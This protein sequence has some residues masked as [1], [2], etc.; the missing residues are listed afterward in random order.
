MS[1]DYAWDIYEV[2]KEQIEDQLPEVEPYILALN[3]PDDVSENIN[4]LFRLFHNY[5][6][7]ADYLSLKPLK[8][9]S[10]K[11]ETVLGC[12][13]DENKIVE[14]SIIEWLLQI[15]DQLDR[16]LE[17]MNNYELELQ[18]APSLLKIKFKISKS[19][20]SVA[21]TLKALSIL[22]IDND[23]KRADKI[24]AY[25][26]QIAKNAKSSSSK[27]CSE[28]IKDYGIIII[29]LDKFNYPIIEFILKN[30][31]D[32]PI[33]S[34][35]NTINLSSRKKLLKLGAN[36]TILN[37]LNSK[38]IQRE[39]SLITKTYYSSRKILIDN[40]KIGEFIQTL[41]PLPNTI[42]K[43]VNVCDDENSAIIDLIKIVKTDPIITANI[44]KSANSPLYGSTRLTTIDQAITRLGK[45]AIKALAMCGMFKNLNPL[46]LSAYEIDEDTFSKVSMSRLS[47]ILK[48]YSKVSIA[49]LSILTSTA[50]LGNIGQL[51]ISKE[52]INIQQD[53]N[54]QKLYTEFD[55]RYAEE[56]IMHITTTMLSAQILN[57]WKLSNDIVDIISFSD[58]PLEAPD[59]FK[60]LAV[61]NHIVY[62]LIDIVGNVSDHIPKDV[63]VLMKK[64]DLDPLPLK[65]ALDFILENN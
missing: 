23:T 35:F 31:P 34:V 46:N 30:Y 56:S 36:N 45:R 32:L 25:L 43:I 28:K 58:N 26:K 63:L 10:H 40:K 14:N 60:K 50:L 3:R 22:Y 13:R 54:F 62:S 27:D 1:L 55:I 33:I 39:L 64:F 37:P 15:K 2:F 9:L 24:V 52:L 11:A 19:H 12:L 18:E 8:S 44:L 38:K 29:N 4:N 61:A 17:Q 51:L 53:D 6:A 42:F 59:E 7:T 65:K 48:W 47:L 57:H 21:D 49:D 16:W 5:K 41:K 20:Q